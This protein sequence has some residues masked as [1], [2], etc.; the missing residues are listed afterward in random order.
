MLAGAIQGILPPLTQEERIDVGKIHSIT[1]V[2]ETGM[3]S[4]R[5]FRQIHRG[6]S[7]SSVF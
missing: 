7:F 3:P 6:A 1:G 2:L 5:P 4:R